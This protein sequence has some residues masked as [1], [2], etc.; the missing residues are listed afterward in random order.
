MIAL[1]YPPGATPLDPS[2]LEGLKLLHITTQAEMNRW[3]QDNINNAIA[4]TRRMRQNDILSEEF[5]C[6][7]HQQMYSKVWKWAGTFRR[8]DKNIGGPW[9]RL[10][11]ELRQLLEDVRYWIEHQSYPADEIAARFHHRL[12]WIHLFPNGN[13][14]HARLATEVLLTKMLQAE[15]FSWGQVN[16]IESG[17]ARQRYIQALKAADN[18]DYQALLDF[19]RS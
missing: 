11:V 6:R 15:P 14:R 17:E 5:L 18:H 4:W 10:G 13:G 3:E 8:S 1:H 2:E 19:V 7:L 12:V 16:L 9:T